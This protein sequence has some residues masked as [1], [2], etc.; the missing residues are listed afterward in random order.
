MNKLLISS[1]PDI[2]NLRYATG[3]S[4]P[5]PVI[6]VKN[7]G[8]NFLLVPLL[9]QGRAN[10]EAKQTTVLTPDQIGMKAQSRGLAEWC[11]GLL[12]Y[13]DINEVVVSKHFPYSMA[14]TLK[15]K[16]IKLSVCEDSFFP[17]RAVK[18]ETEI[19]Q[20]K[21]SQRC[22]VRAMKAAVASI[23]ESSID[24][25]QRLVLKGKLLTSERVREIIEWS[26]LKNNCGTFDTIVAGGNQA[27]DP[28]E[29]GHGPLRADHP[30]VIDIFP[31]HRGHGYYGDITRTVIK[32]P[33]TPEQKK[34]YLTVLRAQKMA[35]EMVKPGVKGSL[36]H[37]RVVDFFNAAGYRTGVKKGTPEGFF[38]GTG[39]G[40]GLDIHEAPSVSTRPD[41]LKQGHVITIEPGLYYPG[42][43]GV[44]IEDTVAVTSNGYTMLAGCSKVFY[45]G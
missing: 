13:L 8:K 37:A 45:V 19:Q 43:G 15:R 23:Q 18:N 26:L 22:A 32:G 44:R 31:F 40:V 17:N 3:F 10:K 33:P 11:E 41:V 9:E 29:S 20:I 14:Q 12:R 6:F 4:A 39:H 42:L 24:H 34:L 7:R 1:G 5:D 36:I 38:H 28:H 2:A 35:L 25:K 27:T 30:V 16:K 21:Q